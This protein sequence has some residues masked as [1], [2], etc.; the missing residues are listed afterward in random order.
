MARALLQLGDTCVR[1][2]ASPAG[3]W[4]RCQQVPCSSCCY[5]AA[6]SATRPSC[7]PA[8]SFGISFH[9][10]SLCMTDA[11]SATWRRFALAQL[12]GSFSVQP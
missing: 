8:L 2:R 6:I 1:N 9:N 10:S 11:A 3:G 7:A 5:Q 4:W 12:G